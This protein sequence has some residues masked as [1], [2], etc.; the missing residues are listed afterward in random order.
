MAGGVEVV[1]FNSTLLTQG[2]S[3]IAVALQQFS[4]KKITN[5]LKTNLLFLSEEL[6]KSMPP[7]PSFAVVEGVAVVPRVKLK[8]FCP[9]PTRNPNRIS[10]LKTL[11]ITTCLQFQGPFT[12]FGFL[13]IYKIN[14]EQHRLH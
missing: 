2:H 13:K 12:T 8:A 4:Q 6:L 10:A 3:I 1:S 5:V 7:R 11:I 9:S 14:R